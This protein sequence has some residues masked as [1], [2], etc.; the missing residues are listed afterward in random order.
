MGQKV[1]PNLFRLGITT[2]HTSTWFTKVG[3][4]NNYSKY[5]HEDNYIRDFFVQNY[6]G[7]QN[8]RIQ[9]QLTTLLIHVETSRPGTL[10]NELENAKLKLQTELFQ[11]QKEQAKLRGD[12]QTDI[13]KY[14]IFCTLAKARSLSAQSVAQSLKDDLEKRL[15]FRRAMKLLLRRAQSSGLKGMKI[16]ISGRLNGAEIARTEWERFGAVSLQS[17][18]VNI[19]YTEEIAHTIYGVLG[20]KVWVQQ[21]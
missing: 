16:Q 3:K 18:R 8:I 20:I 2:E 21:D 17:L 10:F 14:S 7:I 9:R 15:P 1:H 12:F 4:L 11:F 5:L 13:P 6:E 19:D